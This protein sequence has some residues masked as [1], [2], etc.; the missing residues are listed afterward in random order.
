MT[1]KSNSYYITL[2]V[3]VCI[4]LIIGS[5]VN[6]GTLENFE[7]ENNSLFEVPFYIKK[8]NT[9]SPSVISNVPTIIYNNW[10]SNMV[11]LKMKQNIYKLLDMNPDFDYYL[12]SDEASINY[13]K[14]NYLTEVVDAFNTLKPGAFKSDLWRYCL[15]YKNG[16]V[17]LD[18]KYHTLQPLRDIIAK[19]PEVFVKDYDSA[20][21][22]CTN[23]DNPGSES[24]CFYNGVIISPA[25]NYIF[26]YCIDE[27]VNNC[28]MKLYKANCLDVTGPCLFGRALRKYRTS[29]WKEPKF[30]YQREMIDGEIVDYILFNNKRIMES[31]IEYRKEQRKNQNTEHYGKLWMDRNIYNI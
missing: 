2:A 12:Y 6:T 10:H 7:S 25:N 17:Y 23:P 11:P 4:V 18:M 30:L 24:K 26:K 29:E 22:T 9:D 3:L 13:I 31:Y 21:L 28:K 8:R 19:T 14:Q 5:F 20:G 27:V 15:L 16:G 1:N